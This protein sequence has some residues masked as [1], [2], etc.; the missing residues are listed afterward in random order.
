MNR[1]PPITGP[2]GCRGQAATE[3][4]IIA[5]FVLVP[6]FLL[7]PLLGKYIDIKQASIQQ[8]RFEAW[9]YTA[10][11]DKTEQLMSGIR[12]DQ[13]AGRRDFSETRTKG[14]LLFFSDITA[15][16]YGSHNTAAMVDLN[17]LWVDHHGDTLF[18][19]SASDLGHGDL[20]EHITPDPTSGKIGGGLV[21]D[22]ID[23]ID[24]VTGL[25]AKLLHLVG[26][27][28]DFD[29]LDTKGY[30]TSTFQVDVR[31]SRQ[32]VP[33]I[34]NPS[35]D[36]IPLT[37]Q[38]KASVLARG[39]TAGSTENA[40]SETKGLVVTSLLS[41]VSTLFNKAVDLLQRVVNVAKHVL[42]IDIRLPHGPEFGHVQ[43]DLVPYE[44]IVGD[45]RK[46][47]EYKGLYYY[48]EE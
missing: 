47:K 20:A 2:H 41:P 45:K 35:P 33:D 42:P 34:S 3:F 28:A 9:E 21:N 32:V 25:F 40:S 17:P 18:T 24:W 10:W 31:N 46:S 36:S 22:I 26:V 15:P 8:A 23:L 30:F 37:M 44:H 5:S 4:T 6:L 1:R 11:F 29:A 48:A 7:I 27:K 14:N 19:R 38:A 39:W 16:D 43:D 12:S 13:R